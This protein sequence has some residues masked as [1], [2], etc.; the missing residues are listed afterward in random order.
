MKI[1][2][3]V[4][5]DILPLYVDE[6]CSEE[7]KQLVDE[8]LQEC[9]DCTEKLA[10]FKKPLFLSQDPSQNEKIYV[11]HVKKAFGKL[12]RRLVAPVIII[13]MLLIP[14]TWLGINE[15][16][17]DGV[18]YS[19]MKHVLKGYALLRALKN[20]NYEKAFS[21]LNL[22]GLYE[23][24]TE[25]K[26]TDLDAKYVKV[27]LDDSIYYVDNDTYNNFY[28][29]YLNDQDEAALWKSIY[30]DG[31]YMIP[32]S[33]ADLYLKNAVEINWNEFLVYQWNG[34][35][36]YINGSQ[37]SYSVDNLGNTP[38][39]IMPEDYYIQVKNEIEQQ[40]SISKAIIQDLRDIGY[41]GYVAK[42]K[43][44]WI[45]NFSR[46]KEK[47]IHIAG[48]KLS[49]VDFHDGRYQLNYKLKLNVNGEINNDYG[50]IFMANKIDFYPSGGS[51]AGTINYYEEIPIIDAFLH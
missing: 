11:K 20:E 15:A 41:D 24:E 16:Q 4:I 6:C 45:N 3:R 51:V 18:S 27:T 32:V 42:Y 7:T 10:K 14:L 44:Q 35:Y 12:R 22:R 47:G 39:R 9:E 50:V 21:Y 26:E 36:Y 2:C 29:N 49:Y 13:L 40:D 33:K 31:D 25:F 28:L 30:L 38:F 8:H 48:Y 34:T 5:D 43:E 19:S 23:W 46:L 1:S 37:Y 17:G